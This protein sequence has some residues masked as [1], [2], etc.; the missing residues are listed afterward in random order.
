LNYKS[1]IY[2][3]RDKIAKI[4]LNRPDTLN[5]IDSQMWDDLEKALDDSDQDQN[6]RAVIFT[7]AGNR[8]FCAGFDITG[9]G[10]GGDEKLS[11][12]TPGEGQDVGEYIDMCRTMDEKISRLVLKI[13]DHHKPTIVAL[14]GIAMG[15]GSFI[16]AISDIT[17]A[18][19]NAIIAEP[20]L[21]HVSFSGFL[22]PWLIGYKNTLRYALT[23]DS[24]TAQEAFRMGLVNEVVPSDK[25][26]ETAWLLAERIA[27]VPPISV[28][29]NKIAIHKTMEMMGFRNA[30]AINLEMA[31][32]AHAS[33]TK[34]RR[35]LAAIWAEKGLK[36]FLEARDGPFK[37]RK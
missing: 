3:K 24:I 23:G 27:K 36:A 12:I 29:I 1:I 15:G 6:V 4:T 2:E 26:Q 16:S 25:L 22:W 30:A 31:A 11:G 17:I 34:E 13:W 5:T 35:E 7:G 21:R 8:A 28:K 9:W 37:E 10:E 33:V 19:E 32:V 18:A 20:E 14:N